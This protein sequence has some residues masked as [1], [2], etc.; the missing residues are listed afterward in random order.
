M[1]TGLGIYKSSLVTA[2]VLL[3]PLTGPPI[4]S[5][6]PPF[7]SQTGQGAGAAG[8]GDKHLDC[9]ASNMVHGSTGYQE[10]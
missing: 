9:L 2:K 4:Q 1:D 5:V 7:V 8:G 3:V 10:S 6:V